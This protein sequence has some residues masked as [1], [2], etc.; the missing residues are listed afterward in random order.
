MGKSILVIGIA[1]YDVINYVHTYPKEDI[2]C[3]ICEQEK[4]VGGNATNVARHLV[5]FAQEED[6]IEGK[7][8]QLSDSLNVDLC[9]SLGDGMLSKLLVEQLTANI[10]A[11]LSLKYSVEVSG[12]DIP[13]SYVTAALDTGSRTICHLR[14]IPELSEKEL[15]NAV[16]AQEWDW[17]HFE[18]RNVD[19]IKSI[20]A[21]MK[22]IV[23]G[24]PR[25]SVEIE[26]E[27]NRK[28]IFD[29]LRL[30]CFDS[31]FFSKDY[32][33]HTKGFENAI[34]FLEDPVICSIIVS[35]DGHDRKRK[36]YCPWGSKGAWGMCEKGEIAHSPAI[37]LEQVTDSV[38]AGD[39]F[40]AATIF[41]ELEGYNMQETLNYACLRAGQKCEGKFKMEID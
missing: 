2:K 8:K 24:C 21:H 39:T 36:I 17:I 26:T 34:A 14:N 9:V 38:G 37:Q 5:T 22:S 23:K 33:S 35:G 32:I 30:D 11:S 12:C 31:V 3:R 4:R 10:G 41:A 28:G 7:K 25:V 1:C 29:L 18:G 15:L 19:G 6:K 16:Q 27:S 13:T 20:A 40:V